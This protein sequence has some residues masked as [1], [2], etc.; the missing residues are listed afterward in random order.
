MFLYR[1]HSFTVDLYRKRV[2][3]ISDRY[4]SLSKI[5]FYS[6]IRIDHFRVDRLYSFHMSIVYAW[7]LFE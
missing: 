3:F 4:A 1:K 5:V 7:E 6:F 2:K